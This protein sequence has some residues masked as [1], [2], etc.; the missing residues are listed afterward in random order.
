MGQLEMWVTT[1]ALAVG[2]LTG[3]VRAPLVYGWMSICTIA[4]AYDDDKDG[5][6]G[7]MRYPVRRR[8]P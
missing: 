5:Y 6:A 8:K 1:R 2:L 4:S 3:I 7:Q